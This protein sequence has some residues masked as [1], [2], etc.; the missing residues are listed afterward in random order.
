LDTIGLEARKSL[1]KQELLAVRVKTRNQ[2]AELR[3]ERKDRK[4]QAEQTE[5]DFM[6]EYLPIQKKKGVTNN[7]KKERVLDQRFPIAEGEMTTE[8]TL[9]YEAIKLEC[10]PPVR[11]GLEEMDALLLQLCALQYI[12]QDH[13]P[14]HPYFP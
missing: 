9:E 1:T 3:S 4:E 11:K 7:R 5:D 13:T 6:G 12:P 10:T 14:N 2:K 8:E